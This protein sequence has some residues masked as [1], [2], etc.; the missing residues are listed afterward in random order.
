M[1]GQ[2]EKEEVVDRL[3]KAYIRRR[4]KTVPFAKVRAV[5]EHFFQ[6]AAERCLK[7][8]MA[9]EDYVEMCW[10]YRTTPEFFANT[11]AASAYS[12]WLEK[13][14]AG[15]FN[16]L[17]MQYKVQISY[18]QCVLDTGRN[19]EEVLLDDHY[20]FKPWFRIFVS[21]NP[22]PAV[23]E[24]Y[25]ESAADYMQVAKFVAFFKAKQFDIAR[26]TH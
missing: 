3:K 7:L 23:I 15:K 10:L 22:I 11:L 24:K 9:P 18:L 25:G 16:D 20:N 17:E 4:R 8:E 19:V 1:K 13:W 14:N 5:D 26:V 12:F 6:L 21:D 2:T